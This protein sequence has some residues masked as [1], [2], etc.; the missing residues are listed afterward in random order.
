MTTIRTKE[1]NDIEELANDAGRNESAASARDAD[2]D[3]TLDHAEDP[4]PSKEKRRCGRPPIENTAEPENPFQGMFVVSNDKGE[5]H[6][7]SAEDFETDIWPEYIYSDPKRLPLSVKKVCFHNLD[8]KGNPSSVND[9][10]IFKYI[11]HTQ[12]LFVCDSVIYIYSGGYYHQ[13]LRGTILKTLIADCILEYFLKSTTVDRIYKLFLQRRE[14]EKNSEELNHHSP[15]YINFQNG[16]YDVIRN[17]VFPHEPR[18][19][20][21]NQIPHEYDPKADHGNGT[22]IEKFLSYALPAKDDRQMLLEYMGLCCTIDTRQQKMLIMCGDGGTG[23]S[24]TINLIQDIVGKA[25]TSNVAMSELSERFT[26][27]AMM[28]KLLNSCADL[29]IDAL[30]DTTV[31]K[32]LVG[33]DAIKGEF[34]GKDVIS[35]DNYAKLLFSTNELPLVRNEKTDGFYRRLLILNMN[36][37]PAYRDP[38]LKKKLEAELPYLIDLAMKALHEMYCRP[39][40]AIT[41]SEGSLES[42]RQLRK[43]SDTIEAFIGDCCETGNQDAKIDRSDLFDKYADYCKDWGR[44]AHTRNNFYK[45]LRNKGF[46][47]KRS[48]NGTRYFMCIRLKAEEGFMKVDEMSKN[49]I[50][51]IPFGM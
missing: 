26:A 32:K 16:M 27:I 48:S 40:Q 29:E 23:K 12:H 41:V 38:L 5:T 28:N 18:I 21:I 11:T 37:K 14:L 24:T 6:A 25:N 45:A 33:E 20:S 15:H 13:D 46:T 49:E 4:A 50:S 1:T 47:E 19:Y 43:D 31:I 8:G 35:F 7:L 3:G 51:D 22:E 42:A 36:H 17:K 44:A 34:K 39:G 30:D 9:A 2:L 10:R